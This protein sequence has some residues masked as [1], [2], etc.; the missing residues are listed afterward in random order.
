MPGAGHQ[1]AGAVLLWVL[2]RHGMKGLI[3]IWGQPEPP[4]RPLLLRCP[5]GVPVVLAIGAT[6]RGERRAPQCPLPV[7]SPQLKGCFVPGCEGEE[8]GCSTCPEATVM[9]TTTILAIDLEEG[10][11]P[12]HTDTRL[13]QG[14]KGFPRAPGAATR[15]RSSPTAPSH[16][17]Q[18][19]PHPAVPGH[20]WVPCPGG[21]P[22][23]YLPAACPAPQ[24]AADPRSPGVHHGGPQ[25]RAPRQRPARRAQHWGC[26]IAHA[27]THALGRAGGRH[28]TAKGIREPSV[29]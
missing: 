28:A 29:D 12:S 17:E 25:P 2:R 18:P 21:A 11:D 9:G 26:S 16:H 24:A 1:E 19:L 27:S 22:G 3:W 4:C 10:P 15:S 5:L 6:C 23:S 20:W 14:F 7:Q 8:R 13:V